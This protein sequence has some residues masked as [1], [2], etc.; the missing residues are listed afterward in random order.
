[1]RAASSM[2]FRRE[3]TFFT[4]KNYFISIFLMY[5]LLFLLLVFFISCTSIFFSDSH[6]K[7]R[8]SLSLMITFTRNVSISTREE[9]STSFSC[10]MN[11][12][13]LSNFRFTFIKKYTLKVGKNFTLASRFPQLPPGENWFRASTRWGFCAGSETSFKV[14][15]DFKIILLFFYQKKK[16]F[17]NFSLTMPFGLNRETFRQSFNGWSCVPIGWLFSAG[18]LLEK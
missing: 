11:T 16:T 12:L 2:P 8:S 17:H 1:M 6:V 18:F 9:L 14:L 10:A 13:S 7:F 3:D 4:S 5:R 15:F